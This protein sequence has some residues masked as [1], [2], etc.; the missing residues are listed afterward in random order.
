[1]YVKCSQLTS[2][3]VIESKISSDYSPIRWYQTFKWRKEKEQNM[4]KEINECL[5]VT[6]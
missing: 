2:H 3:S 5:N 4:C 1:M 6:K